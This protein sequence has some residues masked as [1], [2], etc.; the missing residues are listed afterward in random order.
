MSATFDRTRDYA[1]SLPDHGYDRY[2]EVSFFHTELDGHRPA[3]ETASGHILFH[4]TSDGH[5]RAVTVWRDDFS[6]TAARDLHRSI[7][8]IDDG[9]T[10]TPYYSAGWS[11]ENSDHPDVVFFHPYPTNPN[12]RRRDDN[13]E[14]IDYRTWIHAPARAF[15]V[16]VQPIDARVS[17]RVEG[18]RTVTVAGSAG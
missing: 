12:G 5:T 3:R 14:I 11:G 13:G 9:S 15:H 1:V 4:T 2:P 7:L 10:V 18:P 16:K 17:V 8:L 6:G